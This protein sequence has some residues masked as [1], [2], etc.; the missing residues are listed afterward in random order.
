LFLYSDKYRTG[1]GSQ[2]AL[3]EPVKTGETAIELL[4]LSANLEPQRPT[5]LF[6][7]PL[8]SVPLPL[9]LSVPLPLLLLAPSVTMLIPKFNVLLTVHCSISVQR[10]QRDALFIQFTKD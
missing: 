4:A 7:L 10:N 6:S 1:S 2:S 8:R 3:C 5:L 9:L